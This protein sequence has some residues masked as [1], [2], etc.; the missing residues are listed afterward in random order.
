M[1]G[2]NS[3]ERLVT[4]ALL[5]S[6]GLCT[7]LAGVKFFRN[8]AKTLSILLKAQG[9]LFAL[10]FGS[11]ATIA[12]IDGTAK[13]TNAP[14]NQLQQI[15]GFGRPLRTGG[16]SLAVAEDDKANGWRVVGG[17]GNVAPEGW[18]FP[19]RGG[20][21]EGV[22]VLAHGEVR[23]DARTPYFPVPIAEG[24]SLLPMSRWGALPNGGASVFSH[25][26]TDYGSLLLDWR[27][28]L[29]GRNV[30]NPTNMQLELF[31][32]GSF[33]WRTRLSSHS[34][35]TVMALRIPSIPNRL[36][37]GQMPTARTLNGTTSSARM[38]MR[39]SRSPN[40]S[41]LHWGRKSVRVISR[42]R[43]FPFRRVLPT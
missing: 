20:F 24:V 29:A 1:D 17:E 21:I 8:R 5:A 31:G 35:G 28:A 41:P 42:R 2:L 9:A 12:V 23:I 33:E 25:A 13:V 14:P 6:L 3:Y 18:S 4:A 43:A 38:C 30:N 10:L 15:G 40:R 39:R 16:V 27:N 22:T 11:M 26:V 34:T 19:C 7:A 32:D 37:R 36:S